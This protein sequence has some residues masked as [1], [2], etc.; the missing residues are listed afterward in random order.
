MHEQE[1]PKVVL[2]GPTE[3]DSIILPMGS[4]RAHITRKQPEPRPAVI[5][6]SGRPG[7]TRLRQP[8]A[9]PR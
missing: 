8:T 1:G 6:R 4:Q 7:R 3:G 2:R 5:G 9:H